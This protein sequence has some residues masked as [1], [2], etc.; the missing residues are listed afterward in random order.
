MIIRALDDRKAM[1]IAELRVTEQPPVGIVVSGNAAVHGA[2]SARL[3]RLWIDGDSHQNL[4]GWQRQW[5]GVETQGS[6]E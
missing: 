4:A 3:G 1:G 2:K 6:A 5:S